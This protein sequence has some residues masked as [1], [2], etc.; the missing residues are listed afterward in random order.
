MVGRQEPTQVRV[1]Y[2]LLI[3]AGLLGFYGG[4]F[5]GLTAG[6]V[7]MIPLVIG[8]LSAAIAVETPPRWIPVRLA[9]GGL[10]ALIV[11]WILNRFLSLV[12][13]NLWA[14]VVFVAGTCAAGV[15]AAYWAGR[16]MARRSE[17]GKGSDVAPWQPKAPK[18]RPP[19]EQD[20]QVIV[21]DGSTET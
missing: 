19:L 5:I 3:P 16:L 18:R 13:L 21:S 20:E 15:A 6:W 2:W 4:Y 14:L 17:L 11:G 8:V 1:R 7:G 9:A 12:D 10:G